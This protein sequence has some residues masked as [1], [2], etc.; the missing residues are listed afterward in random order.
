MLMFGNFVSHFDPRFQRFYKGIVGI[1]IIYFIMGFLFPIFSLCYNCI[2]R[3]VPIFF[4]ITRRTNSKNLAVERTEENPR[5]MDVFFNIKP[6]I[7]AFG[8]S[9]TTDDQDRFDFRNMP[10]VEEGE[11]KRI[12][13][14]SGRKQKG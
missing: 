1:S 4:T 11:G 6:T 9:V 8:V 10:G 5:M 14:R 13:A 3:D 2:R 7:T 12:C